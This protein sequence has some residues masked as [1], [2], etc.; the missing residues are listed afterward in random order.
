MIDLR[1]ADGKSAPRFYFCG[2][3]LVRLH[4]CDSS[5]VWWSFYVALRILVCARALLSVFFGID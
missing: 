4:T 2:T 1:G 5:L 3:A